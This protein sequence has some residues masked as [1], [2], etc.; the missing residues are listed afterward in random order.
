M[1]KLIK[2]QIEIIDTIKLLVYKENAD[3]FKYLDF[4][5]NAAFLDP[6]LFAYFNRDK[7]ESSSNELLKEIMQGYFIQKTHWTMRHSYNKSQIAYLPKIGYFKNNE[8]VD[9]ILMID[10]FEIIKEIHPLIERY[11]LETYR[12]NILNSNPLHNSVWQN[13]YKELE[14]SILIIKTY[15][16][17]FYDELIFANKKIYLHDNAKI[18]N[19]TTIETLGMLYFYV[20]GKNNILYFI[21]ELIHQGSH[22]FLYYLIHDLKDFFKIDAQN[23]F[24]RDLTKQEWDYRDVLGAFH[25]LYTITKRIEGFDLLVARNAFSGKQKHELLGRFADQFSRFNTGLELLNLDEVYTK[26]GKDFYNE[27]NSRCQA[28]FKKY[29]KLPSYFDLSNRDLDFRYD[30]F[31]LLNPYDEFLKKDAEKLYNFN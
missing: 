8:K 3:L 29:A 19:F 31:C 23:T 1:Q 16:P 28:I 17:D 26:K 13:H 11:F 22:N 24:M 10:E 25:G 14:K 20:R 12:G 15:L 2:N 7:K 6:F 9:D 5:E 21:E 27:L 30:E 4:E 18:L